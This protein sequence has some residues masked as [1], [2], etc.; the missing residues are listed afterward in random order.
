MVR[1]SVSRL[2]GRTR[3]RL[4]YDDR[5]KGEGVDI[6]TCVFVCQHESGFDINWCLDIFPL[7]MPRRDG[8]V[9]VIQVYR[10]VAIVY[11][12]ERF[13]GRWI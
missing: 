13:V 12:G 8:P 9:K 4:S 5:L 2:R 6:H 1:L 10:V 3:S 11:H 7:G